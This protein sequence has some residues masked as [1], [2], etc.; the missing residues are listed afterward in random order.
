MATK[1]TTRNIAIITAVVAIAILAVALVAINQQTPS[2]PPQQTPPQQTP[3]APFTVRGSLTGGGA[4]FLNPQM[5]AWSRKVYDLTGGSFVVN[6]Q[7][8]GSGAGTRGFL[9]KT[10]VFGASDVPMP[11]REYEG[12]RGRFV[13]FPVII[14]SIVLVYNIPEVSYKRTGL[15]LNLTAEV[16]SLIYMGEIRQWCDERIQRLNPGLRLP[17]R[18]I[19]AVHRSDGSGTTAAFTLYL[20]RAYE[21]WNRTVGWGFDVKWPIYG[22]GGSA[23]GAR[24][25]EGV[26]S[27]VLK[28]PYSI[29][30]VEFAYWAVNKE[31]YDEVGGVAYIK[32]D[33]D[34]RYYFPTEENV[35]KG[36]AAGLRRY[37]EKYGAYP[38]PTDD[39]NPVSIELSNPPEGYPIM[40]FSYVFLW[41]DYRAEGYADPDRV[42]AMLKEFFR[43]V[44]TEGQRPENVV[45]GYIPLPRELA[46]IG[47]KALDE[48][49]P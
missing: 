23:R 12:V 40:S 21:P 31:K 32:N 20:T 2:A 37:A 45:K 15:Y 16:I 26:A 10:L 34:G 30:Y 39:W 11:A 24:G 19:I 25:N 9:D 47:L 35:I 18:D 1:I 49:K 46:E 44:L 7:S 43:W 41:K 38:S 3:T 8:I 29:G 5:Q 36:A 42:A 48:V 17:C 6:Y 22:K 27:E 4:T 28:T 33:N 14:G 13:Q